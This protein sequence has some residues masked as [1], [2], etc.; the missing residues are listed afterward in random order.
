MRFCLGLLRLS[1]L[2]VGFVQIKFDIDNIVSCFSTLQNV[3][4]CTITITL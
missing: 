3:H 1:L 2:V 4:E